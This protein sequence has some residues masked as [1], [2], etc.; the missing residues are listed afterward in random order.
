MEEKDA[1]K[2]SYLGMSPM[3]KQ[4]FHASTNKKKRTL[5]Y[6]NCWKCLI[7]LL[8]LRMLK[9]V[10]LLLMQQKIS[11]LVDEDG[12]FKVISDYCYCLKW[13]SNGLK[14][15][16]DSIIM[17]MKRKFW[18]F[19]YIIIVLIKQFCANLLTNPLFQK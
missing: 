5:I 14:D 6:V 8:L 13:S 11:S 7:Q 15:W 17:F 4:V 9:L 12:H 19:N 18:P 2:L 3:K 1:D 10:W 16:S